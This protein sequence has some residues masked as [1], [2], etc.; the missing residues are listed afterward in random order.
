MLELDFGNTPEKLKGEYF[1]VNERILS[2]ILS[3]TQFDENSDVSTTYLGRVDITRTSK[4]KAEERFPIPE[5]W[6]TVGQLMDGTECQN[7]IGYRS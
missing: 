6:Y 5:Q 2:E 4:I 3:T 1:S 7:I